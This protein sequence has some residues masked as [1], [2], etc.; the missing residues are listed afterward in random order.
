MDFVNDTSEELSCVDQTLSNDSYYEREVEYSTTLVKATEVVLAVYHMAVI[1]VGFVLCTL[2]V[3]LVSTTKDLQ[4]LSL[5]VATKLII[6]DFLYALAGAVSSIPSSFAGR[7]VLGAPICIVMSFALSVLGLARTFSLV[8]MASDNFLHVFAPIAYPKVS[9]K[10]ISSMIAVAWLAAVV[11]S[12][13]PLPGLL[14]CYGYRFVQHMCFIES[15][16][17][18]ACRVVN[19][20]YW[21]GITPPGGIVTM[22]LYICLF[23]K[24]LK[25]RK[26]SSNR[27][28]NRADCGAMITFFLIALSTVVYMIPVGILLA[29]I[30]YTANNTSADYVVTV[31]GSATNFSLA[32]IDPIFILQNKNVKAAITT[33]LRNFFKRS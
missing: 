23:C 11:I 32:V 3:I 25:L 6:I 15:S 12:V 8:V 30:R 33:K 4:K 5:V 21:S 10:I 7:W 19:F 13:I 17:R 29:V 22:I 14:D 18:S 9:K 27:N 16:C 28:S 31:I 20:M 26:T 1:L 24:A 2:V